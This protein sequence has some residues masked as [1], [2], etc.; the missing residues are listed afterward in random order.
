MTHECPHCESDDILQWDSEEN[1]NVCHSCG[2]LWQ[3]SL[4]A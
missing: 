1:R 4:Q 2:N 3:S